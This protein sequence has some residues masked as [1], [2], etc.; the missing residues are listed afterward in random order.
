MSRTRDDFKG[1]PPDEDPGWMSRL[2]AEEDEFDRRTLWRLGTW[3]AGSVGAVAMAFTA[4]HWSTDKHRDQTALADLLK[5]SQQV[6]WIA[7][8]SQNETRRLAAAIET[9]NGDRDRLYSRVT[10]LEQD[11]NSVTGAVSRQTAPGPVAWPQVSMP[12]VLV[13]PDLAQA[14][15]SA[16]DATAHAKAPRAKAVA[17][18]ALAQAPVVAQVTT[19]AATNLP[20][21]TTRPAET[22]TAIVAPASQQK[23]EQYLTKI[24]SLSSEAG[25]DASIVSSEK[26]VERTEFGVDI[27]SAN[28]V[29]R[30]R[31]LWRVATKSHPALLASLEPIIV[32][33]ESQEGRGMR[34]HLVAGP[35][36]DA[37]AAAKICAGLIEG[38]RNCETTIFDGQRLDM[39]PKKPAKAT[40]HKRHRAKEVVA[41]PAPPE[42]PP[43]PPQRSLS[44]ILGFRS[45]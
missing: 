12:P 24:A 40:R 33:R 43:P 34:L 41:Q 14:A 32:V 13:M 7:R 27:G 38:K 17:K 23:P 19:T 44:S 15:R 36:T 25:S 2:L 11:L 18:S 9:L 20:P 5:Q 45:N 1:S 28:S 29:G 8:D 35:L 6:Q 22:K 37:A 21:N 3:A 30:L 10:V 4:M 16:N 42:P 31:V 39:E 26:V